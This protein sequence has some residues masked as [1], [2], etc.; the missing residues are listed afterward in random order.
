MTWY[1]RLKYP[2]KCGRNVGI[3]RISKMASVKW[4]PFCLGLSM[5]KKFAIP[6]IQSRMTQTAPLTYP[7][8]S[9]PTYS[10][11]LISRGQSSPNISRK[12]TTDLPL[13]RQYNDVIMST[14]ASQITSLTV[15]YSIVYSGEDQRKH[16][17]SASLAFVRGSHRDRWITRTK[18]Q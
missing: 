10:V 2:L 5:L 1:S 8:P 17:S 16:Q 4:R 11:L 14:M 3:F 7:H 9:I 13:G 15:F 18:G 12:T 6:I